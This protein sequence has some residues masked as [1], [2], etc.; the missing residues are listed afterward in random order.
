MITRR[1]R[2]GSETEQHPVAEA[3][4]HDNVLKGP[5][6]VL[7]WSG[8]SSSGQANLFVAPSSRTDVIGFNVAEGGVI[9]V[10][11]RK[12]D[13]MAS[14][15]NLIASS[16][17]TTSRDRTS[18]FLTAVRSI[19]SRS[20]NGLLRPGKQSQSQKNAEQ[21]RQYGEFMRAAK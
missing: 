17:N 12:A 5:S 15:C 10:H 6:S 21:Y 4:G 11:S 14:S 1:R 20:N 13:V 3:E 2:Q 18:E 16:A 9:D 19:Q 8:E 7:L